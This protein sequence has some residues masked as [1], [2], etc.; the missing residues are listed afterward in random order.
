M[1]KYILYSTQEEW[2][3]SNDAMN[4]LFGL[5]DSHGNERYAEIQQVS[6]LS[7]NDFGKYIFPITTTGNFVTLNEF[8]VSDMVEFDPEWTSDEPI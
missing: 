5:P 7:H 2:N 3:A 4:A 8:N 6:N 1:S